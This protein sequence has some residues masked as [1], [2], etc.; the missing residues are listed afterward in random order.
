MDTQ[1]NKKEKE[2]GVDKK[3]GL[4]QGK[5]AK[6]LWIIFGCG[7]LSV[8][9]VFLL[10]ALGVIGYMPPIA[11]L[12][13]PIDKYASQVYSADNKT[14]GTY[15][16]SKENRIYSSYDQ[17]SPYLV[18]ALVATEDERYYSHS[19]ID[20]YALVRSVVKRVILQQKSGGGGSTI[21]QQLAKLLYSEPAESVVERALQKPIEWVIAVQLERYYTKEEIINLYLNKFDFLNNAVGIQSAARVYFN[22][23]P[24]EL[25]LE[26]AATLVGMCKNPSSFNP[27]R[28][29]RLEATRGRRNVVLQQMYKGDYITKNQLDSL[30]RLPLVLNYVRADHKDGLAPYFREYLRMAMTAKKPVLSN[31]AS[32]QEEQ[33]KRDSV[34]WE[35]NPLYGWCNKNQKSNGKPYSLYTD[36]LKI[37][38]TIDSRMQMYAEESLE[39]HMKKTVQ[40]AFNKEKRGKAYAPYSRSEANKIDELLEKAM[41]QSER[42]RKMKDAGTSESDILKTFKKPVDMKVFSWNGEVDT[43]MTP[44]DSIRYHKGFLRSGFMAMEPNGQVK[45]YV[46]GPNFK[47]FQYDMVNLGRRQIGSTVK[48]FLYSLLMEEGMTPCDQMLYDQVTL[49]AE[50]GKPW[51]PR[52]IKTKMIGQMVSV[53][54]GLQASDNMVTAYLM[55]RTSPYN[56][57]R[58]L[59]AYGMT[60]K[61]DPVVSMSL[62]TPEITIAEMVGGYSAFI[63]KGI[64]TAPL[65]VTRIE[66]QHGNVVANFEPRVYEVFSE[67]TYV[68]MIDML[69]AVVDGGTGNRLRWRFNLKGPMGAK[70]GTTNSNSDAWFMAFT[71]QLIGGTWVGGDEPSIHFDSMSEGQ[72]AAAALPV[73]GMFMQKVYADSSLGYSVDEQFIKGVGDP[74]QGTTSVSDSLL[75]AANVDLQVGGGIDD[76]FDFQ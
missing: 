22:K 61:I 21:S 26:E 65:Y 14:L 48:P 32:W 34:E 13:N 75:N 51:S 56:F 23:T 16:Q 3:S 25:N 58:M 35:T 39:D 45:A 30:T 2:K 29:S 36:G 74:C 27:R 70:T 69:R 41:R 6:L 50:N 59:R 24:L 12:E 42:Y 46:G 10:I 17:L 47:Y 55:G 63:N 67:L 20:A 68:K 60:G 33:Y 28:A 52:G 4:K 9:L 1:N 37:Y 31:Y 43:V 73:F 40:P 8:F 57:V 19:G 62:G 76:M 44:M 64:R 54:W 72:G 11:D 7:V 5:I 18:Q 15:S 53:K 38:T 71:P 49:I 66:D